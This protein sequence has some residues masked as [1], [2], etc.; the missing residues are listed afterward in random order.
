[1]ATM[2]YLSARAVLDYRGTSLIRNSL[3]I[4]PYSRS[5]PRALRWSLAGGSFVWARYPCRDMLV[6]IRCKIKIN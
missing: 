3:P 4:G 5:V 2:H 6:L 1:M